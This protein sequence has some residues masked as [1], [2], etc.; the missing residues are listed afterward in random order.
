MRREL[1]M[2]GEGWRDFHCYKKSTLLKREGK[3]GQLVQGRKFLEAENTELRVR[4][5]I[6]KW[7]SSGRGYGEETTGRNCWGW[8][9]EEILFKMSFVIP[10]SVHWV[11]LV[12]TVS[13]PVVMVNPLLDTSCI[14]YHLH[15]LSSKKIWNQR[16]RGQVQS[17]PLR[18]AKGNL[19]CQRKLWTIVCVL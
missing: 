16:C 9:G 19:I 13:S 17:G 7:E 4:G 14:N 1:I 5:Q 15:G 8:E 6:L 18:M 2:W 10:G 11:S 12:P 3:Y